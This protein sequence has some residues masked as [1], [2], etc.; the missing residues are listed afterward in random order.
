M[1]RPLHPIVYRNIFVW[2]TGMQHAS[3]TSD[4]AQPQ[5]AWVAPLVV[6]AAI[7]LVGLLGMAATDLGPW[8]RNLRQ[9][10]WQPPDLAFGPAWTTIY[11]LTGIAAVRVWRRAPS[12]TARQRWAAALLANGALH[13]VWSALFFKAKR[14][15][16]ALAELTLLW[17][18]IVGLIALARAVDTPSTWFLAPYLV[19]VSFAGA[20]NAA[21]VQL[22]GPFG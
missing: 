14:P 4:P 22:N 3:R 9:P 20:L 8:Y 18:S 10:S 6:T 7:T 21:V 2:L 12:R 19:W 17:L 11:V 15:D 1:Q 5:R 13:V 16:W